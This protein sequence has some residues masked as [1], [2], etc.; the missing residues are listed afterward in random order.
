[1]ASKTD[2][3]ATLVHLGLGSNL[4]E[5]VKQVQQGLS[6]IKDLPVS[7]FRCAPFYIS[8]PMGGMDQPDYLNTVCCFS[9]ELPPETLLRELRSIEDQQGRQRKEHWG[10][11][12]LDIDILLYGSLTQEDKEL[13]LPHPGVE[14]RDFVLV[15]LLDL[16]PDL[17]HPKSG[18]PY[19]D[20][21]DTLL[22]DSPLTIQPH[23]EGYRENL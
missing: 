1:M 22:K 13:T 23:H 14:S 7:G 15:P 6:A 10:A 2:S 18:K 20:S 11:R 21:L 16:S 3:Q 4:S 5:P 17:C 19:R 12:T 8:P 9:T